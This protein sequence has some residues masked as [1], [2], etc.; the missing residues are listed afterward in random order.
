VNQTCPICKALYP[1]EDQKCPVCHEPSPLWEKKELARI[2]EEP[3]GY[4]A[5][6]TGV[7]S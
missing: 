2:M 5:A 3:I 1:V 4:E 6:W 7:P